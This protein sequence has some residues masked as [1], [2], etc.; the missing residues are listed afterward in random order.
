MEIGYWPDV[1]KKAIVIPV[2]K[3]GK[4][5]ASI[6]SY[7]PVSLLPSI[8]KLFE[9]AILMTIDEH[10]EQKNILPNHQFGFRK[11]HGAEHQN[12][13]LS[14][15]LKKNKLGK[16][17]TGIVSLDIKAAFDSVWISGLVFKL[18][19]LD[20]APNLV[21]LIASFSTM[22]RSAVR[23]GKALAKEYLT[24]TG[25]PQGSCLSPRLYCI[26]IHDLVLKKCDLS[27]F[28]D[29]T[30]IIASGKQGRKII[31]DLKYDLKRTYEFYDRWRILINADK[32]QF[33][34][35]PFDR[36]RRRKPKLDLTLNN[37]AIPMSNN[38]KYLG[39]RYDS[40]LTYKSHILDLRGKVCAAAKSL[41]PM[42]KSSELSIR[43]RLLLLKQ[44]ILPS[45]KFSMASW[46][47]ASSPSKILIRR[48]YSRAAKILLRLPFRTPSVDLYTKHL[49]MPF[50]ETIVNESVENFL[51][52]LANSSC[53]SL[54][55]LGLWARANN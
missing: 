18:T 27:T 9:R 24:N 25:L 11:G 28:A 15:Q 37:H 32:T 13:K 43:N 48:S 17:S 22:R 7:R 20:F 12:F 26:Y 4:S 6:D 41:V 14:N 38:I 55:E 44:I 42:S 2:K 52:S 21:R 49:D 31:T 46:A 30:A 35:C 8:S 19:K 3:S 54:N 50:I 16:K 23:V 29:D 40:H 33:L 5:A 34:F 36:K 51:N 39:L 10:C 1:F 53:A 45:I 47:S